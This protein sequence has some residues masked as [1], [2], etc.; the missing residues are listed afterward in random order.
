[1]KKILAWFGYFH[2]EN[3]QRRLIDI[4]TDIR[5]EINSRPQC[6]NIGKKGCVKR[7][8]KLYDELF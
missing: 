5:Q 2:K 3:L 1:M 4:I 6:P 8:Q 7:I